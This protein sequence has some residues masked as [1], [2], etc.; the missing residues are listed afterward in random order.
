LIVVQENVAGFFQPV[1]AREIHIAKNAGK[2][3][4]IFVPS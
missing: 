1:R 4:T 2:W 3:L